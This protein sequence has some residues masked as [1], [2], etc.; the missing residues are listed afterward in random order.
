[1]SLLRLLIRLGRLSD[2]QMTL[3]KRKHLKSQ[4]WQMRKEKRKRKHFTKR[5][6][7]KSGSSTDDAAYS[8]ALTHASEEDSICKQ[9]RRKDDK[10]GGVQDSPD[11]SKLESIV[12]TEPLDAAAIAANELPQDKEEGKRSHSRKRRVR[13][14]PVVEKTESEESWGGGRSRQR[15]RSRKLAN[16]RR[17]EPRVCEKIQTMP[18]SQLVHC[19]QRCIDCD[20]AYR[21]GGPVGKKSN[22]CRFLCFRRMRR[23]EGE[24]IPAGF[25]DVEAVTKD[26]MLPYIY[27]AKGPQMDRETAKYILS[28]VLSTFCDIVGEE[29]KSR[30]DFDGGG[31]L[32]VAWKPYVDGAR[33]LC[34]VCA[35][36]I[37]NFHRF[38]GSCGFV[39]CPDCWS[40]RVAGKGQKGKKK[41][42]GW[43]MQCRRPGVTHIAKKL[44]IAQIFPRATLFETSDE[45]HRICQDL[46]ISSVFPCVCE[47]RGS[48]IQPSVPLLEDM[49]GSVPAAYA[50]FPELPVDVP[51]RWLCEGRLLLLDDP[52]HPNNLEAFQC[53]WRLGQPVMVAKVNK[54]L[55]PTLW[56][57]EAFGNQFGSQTA[58]MV[59]CR[60]GALI[61][62][63]PVWQFWNGFDRV[64]VRLRD[65]AEEP[66]LL[67][68]KDWPPGE[69]FSEIMPDR[70]KDLMGGLPLRE[71]TQRDGRLN[72]AARLPDFLG[73]PDLGPKMYNAY[74][75]AAYPLDGTTN[76]HLDMS[77]AV[78][79]LVYV[80][81]PFSESPDGDDASR[82]EEE[83][84]AAHNAVD[85]C[86]DLTRERMEQNRSNKMGALWHIYAAE[87]AD[88]IR[89]LLRKVAEVDGKK[90]DGGHDPIHDQ[91]FYLD[92][93]L[94]KR[95][96]DDYGVKGWAIL[97][98]L[99]DAVFIPAGAP[100]QVRN[101]HSCIKIAEDFVSPE[102]LTHCV[103]LTHE[104]RQLPETHS[105]HEDKLQVKNI[106]FHTVKDAVGVLKSSAHTAI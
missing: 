102:H 52:A 24:T 47:K 27:Q 33:E 84:V 98:C 63:V 42:G 8:K 100:H 5:V 31:P 62:Q 44:L 99:G 15:F 55:S 76:L 95:L 30:K 68:L 57:P 77:D 61:K 14:E 1:M 80:G 81:T 41:A 88:K 79:V 86:D 83:M 74:G 106:I 103:Q 53:C 29:V 7:M 39:V 12:E 58:D 25:L 36:T 67:K 66:M 48:S 9:K 21:K 59:D 71:Y 23:N 11:C 94:R 18:C 89:H 82:C 17:N 75:S 56:T 3:E 20:Q 60:F 97:Q 73:K 6:E 64:S 49:A 72:L 4:K 34:D 38:C 91:N 22:Y 65:D 105:N 101:L 32:S 37:F 78:N 96:L 40:L 35:T 26:E 45:M 13:R 51:H 54:R 70:F 69:D 90:I 50:E 87:D 16:V 10:D 28:H 104:F 85:E 93:E 2:K 46:S 92:L 19:N 43:E